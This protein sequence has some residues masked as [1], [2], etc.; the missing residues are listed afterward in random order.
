MATMALT[1]D[2]AVHVLT[3]TNGAQANT[4]TAE[5]VYE[6]HRILDQLEATKDNAALLVTSGDAKFWSNGI[7]LE[8]LLQQP[9]D[10]L[11][12][13]AAML[14]RLYLRIALLDMPTVACLTGHAYAGG[15]ILAAAFDFRLM[16]SDRGYFCFPEVDV[17]IPFT[18]V[19]HEIL[20]LLPGRGALHELMLTGKRVGGVEAA[21]MKLVSAAW[22]AEELYPKALELASQLAAKNRRVYASIK[23]GIKQR[24]ADIQGYSEPFPR[25]FF[26][27]R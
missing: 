11:P 13:F 9:R 24:L 25:S 5:V 3:L 20:R 1:R 27:G 12:E 23:R 19:M 6:Y 4:L 7:N 2:G 16:R 21:A 22:P 18:P 8:W 14:D 26:S 15:A 10:F 17:Q